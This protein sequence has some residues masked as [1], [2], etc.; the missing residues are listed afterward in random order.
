MCNSSSLWGATKKSLKKKTR[1]N[2]QKTRVTFRKPTSFESIVKQRVSISF[3]QRRSIYT[4]STIVYVLLSEM[5]PPGPHPLSRRRVCPSP[6]N[7]KTK[8]GGTHSPAGEG[9]RESQFATRTASEKAQYSVYS[10]VIPV[11]VVIQ[12]CIILYDDMSKKVQIISCHAP[13]QISSN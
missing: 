9:V 6:R 4:Q 11:A 7:Q 3:E 10:V 5:G 13:L 8:M 2:N 1:K 12:D